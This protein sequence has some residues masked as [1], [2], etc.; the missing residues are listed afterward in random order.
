M[1]QLQLSFA[2]VVVFCFLF[3]CFGGWESRGQ[4]EVKNVLKKSQNALPTCLSNYNYGS[5]PY[6][7]RGGLITC[8]VW[9]ANQ[10]FI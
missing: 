4:E 2:V 1:H 8:R 5:L 7:F 6:T 3:V 9:P 10:T